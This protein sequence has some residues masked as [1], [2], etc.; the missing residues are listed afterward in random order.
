MAIAPRLVQRSAGLIDIAIPTRP[1][2]ASFNVGSNV[3]LTDA[4]TSTTTFASIM[5]GRWV[6]SRS[7]VKGGVGSYP[8]S[9]RGLTRFSFN[10]NDY[11]SATMNG[12]TAMQYLTVE[13]LDAAGNSLSTSPIFVV[14]PSVFFATGRATLILKGT[15][16]AT[17]AGPDGFPPPGAGRVLLPLFADEVTFY[18]TGANDMFVALGEGTPE[19]TV[20]TGESRQLTE[21]GAW[22]LFIR[23]DAAAPAT[24]EATISLVNG[25]QS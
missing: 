8:D 16:P 3:T 12:D 11:A 17:A 25:L 18:E 14:P 21:A 1:G 4:W 13:E 5:A 23:G 24:F 7:L 22:N 10:P 19:F 20:P 9:M 6:K 15:T 2:V